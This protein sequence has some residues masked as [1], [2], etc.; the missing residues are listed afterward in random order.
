LFN[1]K[2]IINYR[3]ATAVIFVISL[4]LFPLV[5]LT[6]GFLRIIL[7]LPF[8]VFIPGYVL[9]SAVFPRQYD[10]DVVRRVIFSIG[11]SIV[12]LPI[13]GLVLNYTPWGI[14]PFP[15][16]V[17]TFLFIAVTT[18]IGWYRQ[19][20][21]REEEKLTYTL[22]IN[23]SRWRDLD[24][25]GRTLVIIM[26]IAVL[27]A[28]GSL[29]Y[30]I[31]TPDRGDTYTEFYIRGHSDNATDLPRDAEAGQPVQVTVV[32]FNHEYQ[33]ADY[34]VDIMSDGN[35]I[36]SLTTGTLEHEEQWQSETDFSLAAPGEDQKVEFILYMDTSSE[37]YFS[38]PLHLYID[39]Y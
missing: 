4:L 35:I 22:E 12:I 26:A 24:R 19:R 16:L 11:L 2:I 38:E 31:N 25:P 28:A 20:G 9:L 5:G 30:T 32:V 36:S 6:S 17:G 21:L 23:L 34:H 37:P 33:P 1:R 10:L 8:A 18:A 14:L 3:R 29:I 7:A 39:V 13:I 27:T 15:I